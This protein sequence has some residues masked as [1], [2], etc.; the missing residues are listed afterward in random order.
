VRADA[1]RVWRVG[2]PNPRALV[3][4]P[5]P[6]RAARQMWAQPPR[7]RI[8]LHST[9]TRSSLFDRGMGHG[10]AFVI[11]TTFGVA[12]HLSVGLRRVLSR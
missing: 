1:Q 5:G 11:N 2:E 7:T 9:S 8:R 4:A 3:Y 12:M 10:D 6:G